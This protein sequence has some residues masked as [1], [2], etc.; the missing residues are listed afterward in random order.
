M[1]ATL[2]DAVQYFERDLVAT[3]A[4]KH[5]S[6]CAMCVFPLSSQADLEAMSATL[7]D[8]VQYFERDLVATFDETPPPDAG[9]LSDVRSWGLDR[10]DQSCE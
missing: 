3:F 1:S 8:A 6:N 10:I 7:A 2:A 4:D 5:T 9:V